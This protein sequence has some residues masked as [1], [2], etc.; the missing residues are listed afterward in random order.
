MKRPS[1]LR[2]VRGFVARTWVVR[3]L[4][5]FVNYHWRI[6]PNL[7]RQLRHS[8]NAPAYKKKKMRVLAP[9]IET[10]HYRFYHYLMFA[11]ALEMRGAEVKVVLC[12]SMLPG[13][14]LKSVKSPKVDPCL[15][16][17]FNHHSV[18][19][20]F[21]LESV[22]LDDLVPP[23]RLDLIR[24]EAE[25]IAEKFPATYRYHGFD[26]IPVVRDS[27]VRYFYGAT[28]NED[29]EELQRVRYEHIVSTMISF[30]AAS[31]LETSFEPDVVLAYM[32]AY[33][34]WAPYQQF[35]SGRD[36]PVINISST[37][38]DY[39][40]VNVNVTDLYFSKERFNRY[41]SSRSNRTLTAN[42]R[43]ELERI[44]DERF[45]G[46]ARIF[47]SLG[48]FD[49]DPEVANK[50]GIDRSKRNIFLFSNIFWDVGMS[51][52]AR[53]FDGVIEWVI[54]T[55]EIV[56]TDEACHLYVKPHPGEKFDSAPSL[57]GVIDYVH[58]HFPRLPG[59]VTFIL[60]EMKVK[61]YDLAELA[62]L[63]VVYNG[64]LGLEMML[65]DV[66]V[67]ACGLSAYGGRGLAIEPRTVEEYRAALLGKIE[68]PPPNR[69]VLD[70]FAYFYFVKFQIPWTL[71][72]QAYADDFV[73]FSVES[74][75]DIQ[76]GKD[77]YL[78][79]L[80]NCVLRPK[81]TVVEAW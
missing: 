36:V 20:L 43:L 34:A 35:F 75:D 70:M 48:F 67:V 47:D 23:E 25:R 12:G 62:D 14:E 39:S 16:C 31:E 29:S 3:W 57:K 9:L 17:R 6:R 78:D 27:V 55:I 26:L 1:A 80:C 30:E 69:D 61:P 81:D 42:E 11:K 19:Q 2:R 45:S 79:H 64:T 68:V 15:N 71:T 66:P 63:V 41:Q 7:V 51:E 13:C 52:C 44:L 38:Y 21:G 33:S 8:S 49:G 72:K 10:S 46:R 50:L 54:K 28:P 74:L 4:R 37:Q 59:N 22:R 5:L 24:A 56:S 77:R 65:H 32:F 40:T 58:G 18:F 76:P 73:G 60:P 53:L